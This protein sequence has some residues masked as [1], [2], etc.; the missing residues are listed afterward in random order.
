M[1]SGDRSGDC[2]ERPARVGIGFRVPRLQLAHTS[3]EPEDH[4]AFLLR[5]KLLGRL[6]LVDQG[7]A[8]WIYATSLADA[9]AKLGGIVTRTQNFLLKDRDELTAVTGQRTALQEPI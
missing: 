7:D 6:S 3:G 8:L 2:L 5:G 4:A 1:R 9:L